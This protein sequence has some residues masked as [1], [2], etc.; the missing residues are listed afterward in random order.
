MLYGWNTTI[1]PKPDL[2]NKFHFISKFISVH[3]RSR[4][5]SA[6]QIVPHVYL[7]EFSWVRSIPLSEH[8]DTVH[9]PNQ[10]IECCLQIIQRQ[11]YVLVY[12]QIHLHN[13]D[14]GRI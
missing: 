3:L 12:A 9:T 2:L 4:M 1:G 11:L 13:C 14:Q 8:T 6:I 10:L 7:G 5:M